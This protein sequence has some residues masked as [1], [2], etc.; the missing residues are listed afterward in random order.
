M[1]RGGRESLS[2]RLLLGLACLLCLLGGGVIA[3]GSRNINH[4]NLLLPALA[5]VP[6]RHV[7]HHLEAFN[8]CYEWSSSHPEILEVVEVTE[9][10]PDSCHSKATVRVKAEHEYANTVWITAR[11]KRRV[12]LARFW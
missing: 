4:L 10:G 11:D 5:S 3:K 1:K 12:P 2:P 6:G 9:S 7:E 8:G